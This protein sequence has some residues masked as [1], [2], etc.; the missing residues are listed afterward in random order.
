MR[1]TFGSLAAAGLVPLL[2]LLFAVQAWAVDP[3]ADK[4]LRVAFIYKNVTDLDPHMHNAT[5]DKAIA[6]TIF[7]GL[8][9]M[10]PGKLGAEHFEPDLATK[11]EV[12]KD[13]KTWTFHLRKGVK[14][15]QGYGEFK[16]ADVE[17]SIE[18]VKNPATKSRWASLFDTVSGVTVVDDYTVQIHTHAPDPALLWRVT[19]LHQGHIQTEKAHQDK[20]KKYR[21]HPV[22]TGPF[23]ID[24]VKQQRFVTVK[25]FP[26]H[27]RGAP[28]LNKITWYFIP[29]K[30]ARELSFERGEIDLFRLWGNLSEVI[31]RYR[32]KYKV[33][34]FSGAGSSAWDMFLNMR[35]KPLDNVKVRQAMAHALPREEFVKAFLGETGRVHR[36]HIP[37]GAFGYVDD[38]PQYEY[39]MDKAKRLMAE[40]GFPNGFSLGDNITQRTY[41]K[42]SLTF[43]QAN[44]AKLGITV[45]LKLVDAPT[46]HRNVRRYGI[47][48]TIY[49]FSRIPDADLWMKNYYHSV[50]AEKVKTNIAGYKNVDVD[51]WTDEAAH[52]MDV[53][54]RKALYRKIQVQLMKDVPAIPFVQVG[55]AMALQKYVRPPYEPEGTMIYG[56]SYDENW[57]IR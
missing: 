20:G 42:W 30:N 39:D 3:V 27:F 56:F 46:Y 23:Q 40:A 24:E 1:R 15:Q 36:S 47:P 14:W 37:Y 6:H 4:H 11:W 49:G 43:A 29:D 21:Y 12:S 35:I 54:K 33:A 55:Q 53:A 38:L 22:G 18:R 48:V 10:K 16:A 25:A 52:E 8:V 34:I 41:G 7:N 19:G 45:N 57:E 51:R 50:A 31:P 28:K 5:V 2:L 17:Y 9:R 32:E 44:W 13:G 26:D